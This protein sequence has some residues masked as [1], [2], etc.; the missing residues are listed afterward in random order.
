[1]NFEE[2]AI[3]AMNDL[4]EAQIQHQNRL[5]ACEA[6]MVAMLHRL[7]HQALPGLA[8]EYSAAM[9]R[10]AAG[11]APEHQRPQAWRHLADALAELQTFHEQQARHGSGQTPPGS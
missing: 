1:M 6:L 8:E 10:I 4:H 7:P 5:L 11:L 2:R 3:K 9:D